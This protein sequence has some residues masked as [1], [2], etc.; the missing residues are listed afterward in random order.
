M[1]NF[2]EEKHVDLLSLGEEG[3]RH[4]IFVK[5]FNTLH[6]VHNISLV[7]VYKLLVQKKY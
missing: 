6:R 2:F 5:D 4:Y 1:P 3:K 7:I